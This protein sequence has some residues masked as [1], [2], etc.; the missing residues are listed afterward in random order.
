MPTAELQYKQ[1][2]AQEEET[3]YLDFLKASGQVA[4][5]HPPQDEFNA[6]LEVSNQLTPRALRSAEREFAA[7]EAQE[8]EEE[9]FMAFLAGSGQIRFP[10]GGDGRSV[11]AQMLAEV[12]AA[13]DDDE[14]DDDVLNV[15]TGA[16]QDIVRLRRELGTY[17]FSHVSRWSR[18][19]P[20]NSFVSS[21]SHCQLS[22][23][24][25][26]LVRCLQAWASFLPRGT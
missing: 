17:A 25:C 6:F 26:R 20:L 18:L 3:D 21:C 11:A 24:V 10:A 16:E 12:D 8:E 13:M 1:G 5:E 7:L 22:D 19:P 2:E 9:D 23:D 4:V 15:L 14:E